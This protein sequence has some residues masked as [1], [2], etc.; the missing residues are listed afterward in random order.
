MSANAIATEP[1]GDTDRESL[2]PLS[3]Q[4]RHNQ[5]V[6]STREAQ[7]D[8]DYNQDYTDPG[9]RAA[10][11]FVT[12]HIEGRPILDLGVGRGRTIPL[13]KPLTSDYRA[14]DYMQK[15]VDASR[16]RFPDTNVRLDD[17]RV[18]AGVPSETFGLV[19]F[20]YNG[21]DAVSAADRKQVFAA[22]HRVL[23]PGGLFLFS[24]LNMQG[25]AFRKRPW[26]LTFPLNTDPLRFGVRLA[27]S[28][29]WT[30]L[31]I[32][33]WFRLQSYTEAGKG[34]R[35][36]PL[37]AHHWGVVAHYTTLERQLEELEREGFSRD[38]IVFDSQE[39]RQ[40]QLGD[41]MSGFDWFH[42]VARRP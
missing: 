14:I 42:F 2:A 32:A 27:R 1:D 29:A 13:L 39:G 24:T 30:P 12:K 3:Q 4:D 25:P 15:M 9:E 8:L 10:I 23:T 19:Q 7:R 20:S 41:D 36:A 37:D 35:V 38:P 28:V 18:L 16:E 17:A 21:I 33:K 5:N 31:H 40:V 11:A 6:W 22:V 26:H 34:Y